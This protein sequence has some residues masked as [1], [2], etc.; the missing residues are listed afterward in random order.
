MGILDDYKKKLKDHQQAGEQLRKEGQSIFE[1]AAKELFAKYPSLESFSWTQWTPYFNDGDTCYF[2][3]HA[4]EGCIAVNGFCVEDAEYK[5]DEYKLD[6]VEE[7]K[8]IENPQSLI[9]E[10]CELINSVDENCLEQYGE[11]RVEVRRDGTV[12]CEHEDYD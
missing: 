12:E 1:A 7:W 5:D 9:T 10:I 3:V 11:G 4:Y 8:G 6:E 2:S